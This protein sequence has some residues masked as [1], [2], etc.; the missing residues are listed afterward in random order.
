[1]RARQ[2]TVVSC[3]GLLLTAACYTYRPLTAPSPPA[4][5]RVDVALTDDGRRSLASQVGPGT[6]HLEG[7]VVRADNRALVLAVLATTNVRGEATDWNGE[8]VQV[9]RS[10]I[11]QIQ[12]R[13]LSIGGTGVLGGAVA[14]SMIAAYELFSGGS[15]S[16]GPL[17][18]GP[19]GASR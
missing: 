17:G 14:A 19:G 10:D 5:T 9:A 12:Q 2:S 6:E 7:T 3:C 18:E 4:G 8:Q 16:Q 11:E 15:S 1:M 13:R